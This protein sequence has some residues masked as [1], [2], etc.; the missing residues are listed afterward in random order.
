[1]G[2]KPEKRLKQCKHT[3]HHSSAQAAPL[4]TQ[5]LGASSHIFQQQL[6][7]A[8]SRKK[9]GGDTKTKSN[10]SNAENRKP[11][12]PAASSTSRTHISSAVASASMPSLSKEKTA[13][14]EM[15]KGALAEF[16]KQE[17]TSGQKGVLASVVTRWNDRTNGLTLLPQE[18]SMLLYGATPAPDPAYTTALENI[19]K[20]CGKYDKDLKMDVI[21]KPLV[22]EEITSINKKPARSLLGKR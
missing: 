22:E 10:P 15:L 18:Q 17:F 13:D 21:I 16:G 2:I 8:I 14:I 6:A 9:S 20:I 1:M 4:T 3:N 5:P 12:Q 19:M 11:A 7:Q